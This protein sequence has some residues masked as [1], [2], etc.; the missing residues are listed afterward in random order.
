MNKLKLSI[1]LTMLFCGVFTHAQSS[2]GNGTSTNNDGS[3]EYTVLDSSGGNGGELAANLFDG[4][5]STKWCSVSFTNKREGATVGGAFVIFKTSLPMVPTH[6]TMT[7]AGDTNWYPGRNWKQWQLYGMNADNDVTRESEKWVPLDKKYNI[8]TDQLPAA[9][10]TSVEFSLSEGNTIPYRYFKIELDEIVSSGTM[11]MADFLLSGIF[12]YIPFA[13]A[14]VKAICVSNWDTDGDGELSMGEVTAVTTLGAV[15]KNNNSITTFNELQYFTGLATIDNH[16]FNGCSSLTSISLPK[17]VTAIGD[18]AFNGCSNLTSVA[19][20]KNVT[21]IGNYAFNGCS[22]I[23]AITF[24]ENLTSI[25]QSAFGGWK[26]LTTITIPENVTSIG[27]D[28]F[29]GC[30]GLI[31][32]KVKNPTPVAITQNTFSNRTNAILIV[33]GGSGAAYLAADYW[34]DF[35][36]I[37]DMGQSVIFADANVKA[38]CI[39]K[40]DTD[41]D[42]ELSYAE[43]A[44]ATSLKSVFRNNT[45]IKSFD[46]LQYFIGITAIES[47][48]FYGCSNL[49][50]ITIPNSVTSIGGY[51]FYGCSNLSS[52]TIPNSVTSIG[53]YA[54]RECS[55]LSS[56]TI[57]N[58]VTSISTFAFDNRTPSFNWNSSSKT[59]SVTANKCATIYY[60]LDGSEPT[61]NSTV[62]TEPIAI[63]RNLIVKAIAVISG[64]V[65]SDIGS[66]RIT[67]VDSKFFVRDY[68][69]Y[70]RLVD[71]TT[72]NVIEVTRSD[73]YTGE[74]TIPSSV[75]RD[76]ISYSVIRIGNNA[77]SNSSITSVALPN[78]IESI[79]QSAFYGCYKLT[80]INIPT[81]V[82]TIDNSAFSGCSSLSSITLPS[83]ITTIYSSAFYNCRQL[84]SV[85]IPEGVEKIE[86][87]AFQ[88]CDM[89]TSLV[90][91]STLRTIENNAFSNCSRLPTV[92]L[93]ENLSTMGGSVFE[94][95]SSLTTIY[96]L[97]TTPP[98]MSGGHAFKGLTS[99]A[100]LFVNANVVDTYM[101][102][103]YWAEFLNISSFDQTPC[104]QPTFNFSNYALA[105]SS[106][107]QGATIYYTTD[108]SEPTTSSTPYT[109]PISFVK[110]GTV[111][112]IAVCDGYDNSAVSVFEKNDFKVAAPVATISEDHV[113]TLT[114]PDIPNDMEGFP[115][116]KFYYTVN[117]NSW[118]YSNDEW[119]LYEGPIQL[120]GANWVHVIAKR[121]G[122]N[123][124]D[125]QHM[126][127]YSGYAKDDLTFTIDNIK[128]THD[129]KSFIN[130][131]SVSGHTFEGEN[132]T[133]DIVVPEQVTNEGITY[134]VAGIGS[135][136]FSGLYATRSVKLPTTIKSIAD[137]AFYDNYYLEEFEFKEG[138]ESIGSYA[139]G[140]N[141]CL[142]TIHLPTTLKTVGSYAF[143]SCGQRSSDDNQMIIIPAN[144]TNIGGSAFGSCSK[145]TSVFCYATN[146][147]QTNNGNPFNGTANHATLYVLA[148]SI[149]NYQQANYWKEFADIQEFEVLPCEAP[150]FNYSDYQL[151]INSR[152]KGATIYYTRDNTDPTIESLRYDGPIPLMQNGTVRAIAVCDGYDNSAVS[153]FEK[154]DFKVAAPVATISEDH[155]VTLTCPDIPNDM[156]GFPETKFYYTVN[157]NS[158]TYSNDEWQLYEGPIQL[159]GANWVHVIAK[160][161]GWNDSDQQ[162]M[163]Y[164]SGYAKDDLTFTIDNIK[165]THDG[166]SF[167]NEVSVSGHTFETGDGIVD[168]IIPEIVTNDDINYTVISIGD[169]AFS[170]CSNLSSVTIPSSVISISGRAFSGCKNLN[171]VKVVVRDYSKFCNNNILNSLNY[172]I[173]LIDSKEDEITEFIIPDGVTTIGNYAF[174]NCTG[175]TSITIPNS[176]TSIGNYAFFG[177][178]N[179]ASTKMGKN[180][181]S[182]GDGA[183]SGCSSLTSITLPNTLET[184]NTYA[185]QSSGLTSVSIPGNVKTI[186]NYAFQ[187]SGLTSVS[188]PGNVKTIGNYAFYGCSN[189]ASI[190]LEEGLTSIGDHA[191]MVCAITSITTPNSVTS[192][193]EFAFGSNYNLITAILGGGITKIA[194]STFSYC[195]NLSSVI[196]PDGV[197]SIGE[198]AFQSCYKLASVKLPES[199][200]T[201][202]NGAFMYCSELKSIEL[203]NSVTV[204]SDNLFQTN[205]FQYIKLGNNVK[206]IGKNAFGSREPVIEI[207]TPTPPTI[208]SDAFPNVE[209]LADLNV[210]VPDASAENKYKKAAVWQEMT[211]SNQNNISEVT[212]ETPGALSYELITECNMQPSK[213]VGLKV[214]GTINADDFNQMLVNMKSLLRLDL[215]G[216]D[217]TEIPDEALKGKTQLK[218]LILPSKLQTIGR[219]AFQGCPYLMGQLDLPSTVTSI[220]E[221]AFTGTNYTSVKLPSALKTIGDNAFNG[222]PIQQRLSLPNGVNSVG[223]RAFAGTKIN[224]LVIPD[225]VKSIGA[226][227]FA[228]SPIQGHV[229]IPDGVTKLGNGAFMNTLISTV[230]LPN[231]IETLSEGLF[232]GCPNLNL[233]YVPDNYTGMGNYA[234]EGCE[235][236]TT[237]RLSANTATMGEYSLQGTPLEYIKVPS[238]V[239]VLSRGV[240][241]NCKNLESVTLPASLTSVEDEAFYGC[242]NLRNMSVEALDPP[243]IKNRSAIRGI[244]TDKCLISIPTESYRKYVLAEYWGQ[245]VQMRNDIAVETE[246]DGEIAFESV[247]EEEDEEDVQAREFAPRR[248]A[249]QSGRRASQLASED[250]SMTYANNGSSV[251]VPQQ[252]KVRFYIIPA[253]GEEI[254]S[255][256]LDGEDIMPY[257]VDGVYTATADKK[258]AKLVVKF[259]GTGQGS[260]GLAG[261]ANGDGT[262]DIADAVCIVN[263]VVGKA[264]AT[265]VAEAADA[266]KDGD[267]D[268]ADAVHIVNYVVGKIDALARE[269][270]FSLPE[271]Q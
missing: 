67:D 9:N 103:N 233:L 44:A 38:I 18:Y 96:C 161:D 220:G 30:S 215:S 238:K 189:L 202:M 29:N 117:R 42:G 151:T 17:S 55:S 217:I 164:Y 245:F 12:T 5:P 50:S 110:N 106:L 84:T 159:T 62:Y 231:S 65:K 160:R 252:G 241:K 75:E 131:V 80:S 149:S 211:F 227:A 93:P 33:P 254:L 47:N 138:L 108:G 203:P 232:Q 130:E 147:P 265:F 167:I 102:A 153:V 59:L 4:N 53:D 186:G 267:I 128:Y 229:T 266:N 223:A 43:A 208:A 34:K 190:H 176:V 115:E 148:G 122:W 210:I 52:I 66:Y 214:N 116:T 60:S 32:V 242:T 28:A 154:N 76:G 100:T 246:G 26:S 143:T 82:K 95:C 92:T 237:L 191:F 94:N 40:W 226:N 271:P 1:L 206:S 123:D 88:N 209:Y 7:T 192:I 172:P 70:F 270:N 64:C 222:V 188:I 175:L 171:N 207:S 3:I 81:K 10:N 107:T 243:A 228:N 256:T 179:L 20:P 181:S 235:G 213:V 195:Q 263:H 41:G 261:D 16:A 180:V 97:A 58:S 112:A 205:N 13:D 170:N 39:S 269:L 196:I 135:N 262:V 77:F 173:Q 137:R 163:D 250:E 15:F 177:C 99:Q 158:W 218:E 142:H 259:S 140:Y 49:S 184:I 126:D 194:A 22:N 239:E 25:G 132:G 260:A 31:S 48:A 174:R 21:S 187:S 150:T 197:T 101:N 255:A 155:V 63:N 136:A 264:N 111:R 165:Y 56:I 236:L 98:A 168:V 200:T 183:F 247:S 104:S 83:A 204:I 8:G 109:V 162:H 78:T 201:M 57:P 37:M 133:I 6:Y 141:W 182:I 69:L 199:L 129:G 125:Q 120:T 36:E 253:E 71:N 234:F 216:C 91:P 257:I 157:R 90:L 230:F 74:I 219:S 79:G 127:Y 35:Y 124:S 89:L 11:Q 23:T 87:Q 24:P 145:V 185:F 221:S 61:V 19:L 156:E 51:A 85:M 72:E 73:N 152:T 139:F 68:G 134:T 144:V 251:Y 2:G 45:S 169:N 249:V 225:G 27:E 118:T 178:R 166:K 14:N 193:G 258:N 46:E 113:V 119:Q 212:V 268:I 54:F 224:G 114:C 244:N 146:L 248:A 121:D 240:M 105:I 198:Q 86:R